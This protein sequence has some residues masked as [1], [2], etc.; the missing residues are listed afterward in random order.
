VRGKLV[1]QDAS[2]EPA[3][4]LLKRIAREKARL[5][6]AGEMRKPKPLPAVDEPPFDLP[7]SWHWRASAKS[8]AVEGR[9][10]RK[11]HLLTST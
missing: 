4:E 5:V 10:Y 6:K 3:S 7:Q 2:D 11:R 9:K 8:R 1:P